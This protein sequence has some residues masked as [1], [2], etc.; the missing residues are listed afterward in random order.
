[1]SVCA[2]FCSKITIWINS[3]KLW[4]DLDNWD[5][6]Q[7]TTK[8]D[9]FQARNE[10]IQN[11]QGEDLYNSNYDESIQFKSEF[12]ALQKMLRLARDQIQG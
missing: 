3:L 9:A 5:I 1:M 11:S 8:I 10:S 12:H 2:N 4:I 6:S 7:I